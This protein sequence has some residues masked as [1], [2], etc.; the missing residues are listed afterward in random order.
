MI[1]HEKIAS[2]I[3]IRLCV[4]D[5]SSMKPCTREFSSLCVSRIDSA[6]VFF[7]TWG[8]LSLVFS[9]CQN[10]NNDSP[11]F[12]SLTFLLYQFGLS[13]SGSGDHFRS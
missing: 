12:H 6:D 13:F 2:Y 8:I 4:D 7:C 10:D 9:L 5:V 11:T 1:G 3:L